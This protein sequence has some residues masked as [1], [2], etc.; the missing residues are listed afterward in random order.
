MIRPEA[1]PPDERLPLTRAEEGPTGSSPPGV[2][3]VR[4]GSTSQLI[5]TH[6]D[7]FR[8]AA[9]ADQDSE[10][11]ALTL[12]SHPGKALV[13]SEERFTRLDPTRA[14]LTFVAMGEAGAG[15]A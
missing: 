15:A 2:C 12:T 7:T 1:P 11:F 14:F 13:L 3:L 8:S 4:K 10:T 5:F 6:A 9:A